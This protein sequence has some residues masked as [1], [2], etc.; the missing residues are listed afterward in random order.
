MT[1]RSANSRIGN[2]FHL[3]QQGHGVTEFTATYVRRRAESD[4]SSLCE[5]AQHKTRLRIDFLKPFIRE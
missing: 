5:R 1:R 2:G 4:K 3:A